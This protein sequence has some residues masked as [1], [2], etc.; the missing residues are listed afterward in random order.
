MWRDRT[1][2]YI[3]YRQSYA[4]HPAK[5][6]RFNDFASHGGESDERRG[7]MSAGAFQDEGDAVIEMDLLPPRWVDVQDEV[8]EILGTIAAKS[9]DLDRLHQ[10]HVLP[11]FEEE[12]VKKAEEDRIERLTQDITRGFHDCQK[13]I[14]R[15]DIMVRDS[16]RQGDVSRG[17]ET[18]ARNI[19]VSLASRVQEA[20][21]GFRKK[22][23]NYL[24]K[25][26]LLGGMTAPMDRNSLSAP[27][28]PY[29]DPSMIESETDKSFS[30]ST[31]Q[32]A[33]QRQQQQ[34]QTRLS[35]NDAAIAQRE[36]EITDI[37]KGIIELADIFKDLQTMVIDQGTILDRIDYNVERM[38][39][40]VKAAEKDLVVAKGYQKKGVKRKVLFLLV[41]VV[42]GMFILL[43]VKPKKGN[44][45]PPSPP[46][47]PPATDDRTRRF[48]IIGRSR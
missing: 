12:D 32:M 6:R 16:K 14:Q 42:I 8:T 27:Q 46:P 3:S 24:K 2:L 20:S 5:K 48:G 26:R 39:T 43:L 44:R 17:D 34:K 15:I 7:L 47:P 4:H 31:L 25:M 13:A 23:S 33:S 21:A 29:T 22:Q 19:Q 35:S 18:M 36:R 41:L 10:K 40:H 11:G 37:A 1:N 38:N 30:Q 28:N 45:P 9:V